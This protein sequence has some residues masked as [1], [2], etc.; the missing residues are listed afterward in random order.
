VPPPVAG[1]LANALGGMSFVGMTEAPGVVCC[2]LGASEIVAPVAVPPR[3]TDAQDE[4]AEVSPIELVAVAVSALP[5]FGNA[6]M[7]NVDFPP[8]WPVAPTPSWLVPMKVAPSWAPP[9]RHAGLRKN[10]SLY[11]SAGAARVP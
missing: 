5:A 4:N 10:S 1:E 3:L 8:D 9:V 6:E 11:V 7:S 2:V